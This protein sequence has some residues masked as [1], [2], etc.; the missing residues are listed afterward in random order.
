MQPRAAVF[1]ALRAKPFVSA[2][3]RA[4]LRASALALLAAAVLTTPAG[5]GQL[6][7]PSA[8]L[9]AG[10]RFAEQGGAAIYANVCAACHQPDGEGASGAGAYPAL[11]GN[12]SL[13]SADEVLRVVLGGQG[14]MPPVGEMMSD[15]QV[16]DVVNYVRSRF[17][18]DSF[19]GIS[20]AD[21]HA[22]R[23]SSPSR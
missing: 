6:S 21:A 5:A 7:A 23:S 19:P 1:P 20:A 14:G 13:N 9:S 4:G 15:E 11:A 10:R 3:R 2:W 16:A 22:A 12:P 18:N 8:P 17:G